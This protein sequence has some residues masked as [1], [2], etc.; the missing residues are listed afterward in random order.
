MKIFK[1]LFGKND[2]IDADEIAVSKDRLLGQ[3]VIVDE[4]N[5]TDG[6]DKHGYIKFSN[7]HMICYGTVA[8]SINLGVGTRDDPYRSAVSNINFMQSFVSYPNV[9]M[10][11]CYARNNGLSSVSS[12]LVSS[13]SI[14]PSKIEDM[15]AVSVFKDK[16]G[17]IALVQYIAIGKWK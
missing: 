14:Q 3:S 11:A 7:G 17:S 12:L 10:T 6:S 1:N 16:G 5:K 4:G 13:S 8:I 15:I 2:K 9:T